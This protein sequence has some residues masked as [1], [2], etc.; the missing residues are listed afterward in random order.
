LSG[1]FS[2]PW[3]FQV[4]PVFQ[5]ASA[6]PYNLTAGKDLTGAGQAGIDRAIN[7]ATGVEYS[8]DA[9]HGSA[10]WDLDARVTKFINLWSE[11]RRVGLFAEFYN[12]TNKANFGNNYNGVATSATYQQPFGFFNNGLTYPTSRQLQLGARFIF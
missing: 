7:P 4:S 11:T 10:T 1:V 12:I 5:I 2:L 8:V 6:P 9:G 3:G